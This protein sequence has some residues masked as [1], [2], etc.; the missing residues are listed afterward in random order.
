MPRRRLSAPRVLP[1]ASLI[2]VLAKAH[3]WVAE[4]RAGKSLFEIAKDDGHSESYVRVRAQLAFL[5]PKIQ[6]AVLDGK[7]PPELSLERIVRTKKYPAG[8]VGTGTDVWALKPRCWR[9][10]QK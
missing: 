1:D 2:R 3:R 5:S 9:P 4:L 8:L 7:Q 10:F 6:Q